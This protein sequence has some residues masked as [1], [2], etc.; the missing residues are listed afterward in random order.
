[1]HQIAHAVNPGVRVVYVDYDEQVVAHGRA[2]LAGSGRTEIIQTDL[3]RPWEIL[4]HLEI[5]RL[6]DF[7]RPIGLLLIAT[8]DEVM[9]LFGDFALAA[10]GLVW[11]PLWRPERPVSMETA[12][13]IW[14]YAGVGRKP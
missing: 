1:M 12:R 9:G 5:K 7:S 8:R 14:F 4:D 11:A 3:R 2:L 13:R 6:L 10:F